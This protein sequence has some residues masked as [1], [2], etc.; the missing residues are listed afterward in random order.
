MN[1]WSII[2]VC[3]FVS[4]V[5]AYAETEIDIQPSMYIGATH[6]DKVSS[7]F[8]KKVLFAMEIKFTATQTPSGEHIEW[9]SIS[10]SQYEELT[11]RVSQYIFIKDVCKSKTLPSAKDSA[12][13]ELSCKK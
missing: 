7:D 1:Y 12:K 5:E 4:Q 13:K 3:V 11:N 9:E 2:F 6:P 10:E 8:L